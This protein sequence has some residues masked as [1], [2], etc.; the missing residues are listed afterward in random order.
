M[1]KIYKTLF[2]LLI[3][4]ILTSLFVPGVSFAE[5]KSD[6]PSGQNIPKLEV[7]PNDPKLLNGH[8]Y[9]N[10]GPVCQRYTY[11][12][13]YV[14]DKGRP[15]EYVKI[16]FNGQMYDMD[17]ENPE[18][19]DYF[20][21]VKYVYKY[22]PNKLG[23]NFY[24]FEASN[25]LGKA[26]S[27]IID[28]PD[29]GPVLFKSAFDKNEVAVIDVTK[30]SKILSYDLKDEWVGGVAL[31]DDG[32]YLA[33]KTHKR[34]YLFDTLKPNE[35]LWIYEGASERVGD[36]KGGIDISGDG[37]RIIASIGGN[38]IFFNNQSNKPLWIYQGGGNN[39][40][41]VAISKDGKYMAMGTAGSVSSTT[42][43]YKSSETTN[44][45]I[46]WNEKSEVPLWQYHAEGN[47][48]DVSLSGDG[49]FIT[50][51][52][53]C[54][55]R[56]FYFF[57]KN[58]NKPIVRSEMLTRDSP[59][60]RAKISGDGQ[61]AAVG[62]ESDDGAVFLF[63]KDSN[64]PLWKAPMPGKSSARALNFTSDGNYIGAATFKGDVFIFGRDSNSPISQWN[65]AETSFGG[66]DIAEDGSFVAAGGNDNKLHIFQKGKLEAFIINFNEYVQEVDISANG[67]YIAAG[68][69][70]SVYF[71]EASDENAQP[72][73]CKEI[74]EP[75]IEN[76]NRQSGNIKKGNVPEITNNKTTWP[77]ILFGFGFLIS[78]LSLVIY[79]IVI[80]FDLILIIKT[81]IFKKP[82]IATEI[83]T[84]PIKNKLSK[85]V[86]IIMIT[87]GTILLLLTAVS[88]IVNSKSEKISVSN[89]ENSNTKKEEQQ[90]AD[91]GNGICEPDFGETKANCPSDCSGAN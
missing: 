27:N 3:F 40:Y 69:G 5:Y 68:T 2:V 9:P 71:F 16:Y 39:A 19:N 26:R 65:T 63:S 4:C 28:S 22:V 10:W 60:H 54:P 50:G 66:I 48:H 23:S 51:A 44:L 20:R 52:T 86:M 57:S 18:N 81:K 32:K 37:T 12:V 29:N 24:F 31:S 84:S 46:L 53:G 7:T 74:K 25:G 91:C 70:G 87:T 88:V 89:L 75:P 41:N 59:V 82:T 8:V 83:S 49:S 67:K 62:S 42:E 61:Y 76:I 30:Q 43:G 17:K 15:P 14:D 21:G 56:R 33:V 80:K 78:F 35:P 34:I 55:D 72:T 73:E 79:F 58:S 1:S 13:I 6:I 11:S 36:V 64:Q 77:E 90:K 85:K 47:F 45:L 38:A